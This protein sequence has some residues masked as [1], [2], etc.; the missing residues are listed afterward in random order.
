ME[1]QLGD[2]RGGCGSILLSKRTPEGARGFIFSSE[3]TPENTYGLSSER[4]PEG[5]YG[6]ISSSELRWR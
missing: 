4:T 1:L 6:S 2:G 5:T 3:T